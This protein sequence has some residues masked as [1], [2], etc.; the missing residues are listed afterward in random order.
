MKHWR[1]RGKVLKYSVLTTT[2]LIAMRLFY[3]QDLVTL[4]LIFAVVHACVVSLLIAGV[5]L[6]HVIQIA[7]G[8]T[9]EQRSA[10]IWRLRRSREHTDKLPVGLPG[11]VEK[12]AALSGLSPY[13]AGRG[14]HAC[15]FCARWNSRTSI[16][17]CYHRR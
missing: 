11:S 2:A 17:G 15:I 5:L 16:D 9:K 14:R 1:P 7:F 6:N 8:W 13:L 4:F 12:E 10:F 3:V